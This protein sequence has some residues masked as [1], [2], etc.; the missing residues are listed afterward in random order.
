VTERVAS[1]ALVTNNGEWFVVD[2]TG[3][4]LERTDGAAAD[5]PVVAIDSG[6]VAPGASQPAIA[7]ALDLVRRLTPDLRAWIETVRPSADGTVDL[8]LRQGIRVELGSQ[9]HLDDKLSDLA[10]VLTRVDLADLATI[11]L[12]VVHTPVLTRKTP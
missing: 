6:A 2:G 5:L 7:G 4:V 9:A 8:Q 11:D 12:T 3:R 1:A 10:T